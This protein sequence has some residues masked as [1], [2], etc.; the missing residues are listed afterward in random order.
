MKENLILSQKIS[1]II[2]GLKPKPSEISFAVIDL[3]KEDP[4]IAGYNMDHFI[5]PASVYKVFIGAEILRKIDIKK[6]NLSDIVEVSD[7]NEVDKDIRLF[8]K[9]TKADYRPLLKGG[10]KVSIDYLLDLMFS[11][12]DNTASNI[13]M[14]IADREDINNNIILPNGWI[15]SDVTRKFVNRLKKE[16]KYQVSKITLSNARHLAELFYK[17]DRGELV[18]KWVSEKLIMYMNKWNRNCRGGLFIPQFV[19]Y[20]RKGGYLEINGYK[21]N[22]FKAIINVIRKGYAINRWSND[23]GVV[24]AENGIHYTVAILTLTKSKYP[25]VNFPMKDFSKKIFD[26]MKENKT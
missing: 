6:I 10:E 11:R 5:Y 22:F 24:K 25:W 26:L 21:Y 13:L 12:S 8:P 2:K 16:K 15:G 3:S 23:V 17:I 20:Y 14:D 9:T 19:Q 4:E 7:L 18:N 1:E